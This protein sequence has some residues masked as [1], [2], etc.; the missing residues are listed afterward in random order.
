MSLKCNPRAK[1]LVGFPHNLK[2][3]YPHFMTSLLSGESGVLERF[4]CE[5]S[6]PPLIEVSRRVQTL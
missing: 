2:F 1:D 6:F 5:R 3:Q 4:L